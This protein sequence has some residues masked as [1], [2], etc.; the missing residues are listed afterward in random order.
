[1][2]K[3]ALIT[4]IAGQDGSYLAEFLLGNGYEVYGIRRRASSYGQ[5]RIKHIEKDLKIL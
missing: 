4:G 2:S 5:S 1:M 3:K